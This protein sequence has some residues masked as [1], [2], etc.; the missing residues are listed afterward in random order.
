MTFVYQGGADIAYPHFLCSYRPIVYITLRH[1]LPELIVVLSGP[2]A[3]RGCANELGSIQ[4]CDLVH[5]CIAS[6]GSID[7]ALVSFE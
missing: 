7:K 5:V 2:D 6:D 4:R 1:H 3:S